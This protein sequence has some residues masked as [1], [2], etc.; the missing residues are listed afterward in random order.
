MCPTP[1]CLIHLKLMLKWITGSFSV[2]FCSLLCYSWSIVYDRGTAGTVCHSDPLIPLFKA[3]IKTVKPLTVVFFTSKSNF[4]SLQR[5]LALIKITYFEQ[6][7]F[8]CE[9]IMSL[10]IINS[11]RGALQVDR[12]K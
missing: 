4:L 8:L 5:V 9:Q 6:H 7:S 3:T 10:Y 1:E 12:C 2:L 11:G